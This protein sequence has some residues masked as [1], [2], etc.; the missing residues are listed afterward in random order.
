MINPSLLSRLKEIT[1]NLLESKSLQL[2]WKYILIINM[3][4]P[5]Y[6]FKIW[7]QII[8][9]QKDPISA[10]FTVCITFILTILSDLLVAEFLVLS[11]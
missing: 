6:F 9:V 11:I 7:K 8:P 5:M 2:Q 3:I 1:E 4:Q 10:M